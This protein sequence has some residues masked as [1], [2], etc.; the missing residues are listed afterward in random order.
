MVPFLTPKTTHTH[1]MGKVEKVKKDTCRSHKT[2]EQCGFAKE[3]NR[4]CLFGRLPDG[5]WPFHEVCYL[6]R[7]EEER[8][9]SRK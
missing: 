6:P 4:E 2:E 5:H 8:S 3:E 1:I 9:G 7:V